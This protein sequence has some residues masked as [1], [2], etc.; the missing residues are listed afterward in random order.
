MHEATL[1]GTRLIQ[2][3]L[4]HLHITP[5]LSLPFSD[6]LYPKN[7]KFLRRSRELEE[8]NVFLCG[9]SG[10]GVG[11]RSCSV[12]GIAGVGKTQLANEFMH[13]FSARFNYRLWLPAEDP[14]TLVTKFGSLYTKLHLGHS[15]TDQQS[16]IES[17]KRWL[18]SSELKP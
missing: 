15:T 17:V 3:A 18:S 6:L 8:L 7:P 9:V 16:M 10:A 5:K 2:D 11:V 12:N 13:K 4:P 14:V 1:T